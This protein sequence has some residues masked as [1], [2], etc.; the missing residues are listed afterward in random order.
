MVISGITSADNGKN[1]ENGRILTIHDRGIEKVIVTNAETIGN[2]L[3]EA[4]ILVESTD[5]V[6]PSV[7][8]KLVAPDYQVNVYRARP[9]IVVDGNV[10]QKIV[11]AY[12]T[13]EQITQSIG[14]KLYPEDKTV[15]T[16]A[17]NLADG[18]SLQLTIKRSTPFE[19]DFYGQTSEYRTQAKTV[20][21][22]LD[23]KNIKL[24]KSDR[25]SVPLNSEI[26]SG[27]SIRIWRE[28]KQ[29]VTVEEVVNFEIEKIEDIDQP[30]SYRL[31]KSAGVQGKRTVTYEVIVQDGQEVSRNEIA[32]ITIKPAIKQV[33]VVGAK[34][35]YTTPSENETITW[36]F[37]ISQGFNR[38]Q[39]AGI[40]GNL[41]QE[42]G[43]QTSGDGL[44]QWTG[45]RK[46]AL[47]S[48]PNPYNIYTQ[49]DYLMSEL[50]G[51]YYR[52]RDNIKASTTLESATIIFQNQ[53]E[54][55]GV[56]REESRINFARNILASH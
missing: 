56:C 42:H 29:T 2:A 32:S 50:N 1:T 16:T 13:A 38:Y 21:G 24:S 48:M 18:A 6:E 22:M 4:N 26:T 31:V 47:M 45:G 11:T 54:R 8:Q 52:V 43:F 10:R 27:M 39:T 36:N 41:M 25:V 53:F 20:A 7:S 30:V 9:V 12:Q 15:I 40:M 37:L 46:A 14:I 17:D 44:A 35:Q 3:K 28:G 34:G 19:F 49:L 23:E 51:S 33:E 55:C 5:V